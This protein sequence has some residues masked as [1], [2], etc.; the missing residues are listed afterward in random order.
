[1]IQKSLL[2]VAATLMTLGA[3]SST[4]AILNGGSVSAPVSQ[5]V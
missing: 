1:M 3:F 5:T 2:A 4:L